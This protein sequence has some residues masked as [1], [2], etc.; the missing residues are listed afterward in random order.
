MVT[1]DETNNSVER[2][3]RFHANFLSVLYV[4]WVSVL[5]W[6][7]ERTAAA[8]YLGVC[9]VV[10]E[11]IGQ[12]LFGDLETSPNGYNFLRPFEWTQ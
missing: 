8:S 1:G 9:H 2:C 5:D 3:S 10:Q 4:L 11:G 6:L 12:G 7:S